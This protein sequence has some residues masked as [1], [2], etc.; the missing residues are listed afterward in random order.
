MKRETLKIQEKKNKKTLKF[1]HGQG[2]PPSFFPTLS[3][4]F[5]FFLREYC[6]LAIGS[7]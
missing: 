3:L 7:D 5:F 2:L 1:E 6:F 4:S